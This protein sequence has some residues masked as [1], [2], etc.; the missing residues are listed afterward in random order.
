MYKTD[1]RYAKIKSS[2]FD[3]NC[4]KD[5]YELLQNKVNEAKDIEKR[6]FLKT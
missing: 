5:L 1:T 6:E 2:T 3:F 4:L